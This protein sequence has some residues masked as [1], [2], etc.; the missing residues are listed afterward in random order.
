LL[1]SLISGARARG[2]FVKT[3]TAVDNVVALYANRSL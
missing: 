2:Y 3:L 1:L